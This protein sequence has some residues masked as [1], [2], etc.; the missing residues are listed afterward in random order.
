MDSEYATFQR[1]TMHPDILR[2]FDESMSTVSQVFFSDENVDLL[3][4]K[5]ILETY[6][7]TSVR[8]PP[9]STDR[10]VVVM[11]YVHATYAKHLPDNIRAQITELDNLVVSLVLPDIVTAVEQITE[12]EKV[13][14]G[15]REILETPLNVSRRASSENNS[16]PADRQLPDLVQCCPTL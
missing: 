12:Y 1:S 14:G 6:R 7:K 5:I 16:L 4:K 9:Q 13:I 15:H 10:L 2:G 3:Q 8:I 11:R